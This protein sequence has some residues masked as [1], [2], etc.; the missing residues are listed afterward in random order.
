MIP[1]NTITAEEFEQQQDKYKDYTVVCYCTAGYRSAKYVEQLIKQGIH[2]VNLRGSI[3]AWT[4]AGLPL[5]DGISRS[6]P[7]KRVHVYAPSWALQG[8]GYTAEVF[9]AA[10]VR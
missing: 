5:V 6:K 1:G 4:Q 9:R 2:A 3:L 7:T 8:E 10:P